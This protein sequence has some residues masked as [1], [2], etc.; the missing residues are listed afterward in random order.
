MTTTN[1]AEAVTSALSD[2]P[3]ATAA[4]LAELAGIGRSTANKFLAALEREGKVVRRPGG[5][6]GG[7][8]AADHWSLATEQLDAA[9]TATPEVTDD[10]PQDDETLD[11][12]ATTSVTEPDDSTSSASGAARLGRG[13]L[14]GLVLGYLV[15]HRGDAIGPSAIAKALERSSGAVGNACER[16]TEAGKLRRTSDA[17]RRYA[18][19]S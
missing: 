11:S 18:V 10:P 16:L 9:G 14:S 7:R 1:P 15:E 5:H 12:T 13:E 6:E 4:Q 8:R 19:A 2:H 17:P 3:E